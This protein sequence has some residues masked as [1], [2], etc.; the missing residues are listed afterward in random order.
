MIVVTAATGQLGRLVI[1]SLLASGVPASEVIATSRNPENADLGVQTR[2]A[3]YQRPETLTAAFEGA[4][5]LLLISSGTHV[6][7]PGQHRNVVDAAKAA[8]VSHLAYT[9]VLRADTNTVSLAADHKASEELI[10]ASG[11]PYTFLRNGWYFE[12]YTAGAAQALAGGAVI[13]AAKDGLVSGATR[14]DYAAAAAA[15][16]TDPNP[17]KVYELAGDTA[18][19][20]TDLAAEY[21]AQT[22]TP[23]AYRDLGQAGYRDALLT[24]GLPEFVAE[25]LSDADAAVSRGQL[26]YDGGDLAKLIGRPT[27][28]LAD[29]VGAALA[30]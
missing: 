27:T 7:R 4:T 1:E 24:A 30:K 5:R 17:A 3:D 19:T 21:T 29:A 8:G 13:G 22:G 28:T 20:L 10:A 15:V 16:L 14:A 12:N 9:S 11:L 26:H 18:F 25:L 2:L 23:V 6:D